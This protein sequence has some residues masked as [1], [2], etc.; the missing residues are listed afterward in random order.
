[1]C[2]VNDQFEVIPSCCLFVI[3]IID[4]DLLLNDC[5]FNGVSSRYVMIVATYSCSK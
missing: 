4:F 3:I 5:V 1:M 2:L